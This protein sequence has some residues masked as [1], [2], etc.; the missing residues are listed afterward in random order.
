MR[1]LL[2]ISVGPNQAKKTEGNISQCP[3]LPCSLLEHTVVLASIYTGSSTEPFPLL[4]KVQDGNN[5]SYAR[6]SNL[7]RVKNTFIS[8]QGACHSLKNHNHNLSWIFSGSFF[9]F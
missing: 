9:S 1:I 5:I 4:Q 3:I 7:V 2:L 8:P 6:E